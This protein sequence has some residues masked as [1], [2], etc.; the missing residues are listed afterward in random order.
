MPERIQA[1]GLA[2]VAGGALT[3]L[4]QLITAIPVEWGAAG[5]LIAGCG[6]FFWTVA[7]QGIQQLIGIR[8]DLVRHGERL[9]V[10][11]AGQAELR[12]TLRA[13]LRGED[14]PAPE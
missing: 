5:P 8:E 1:L 14:R 12:Q 11:Q 6:W 9:L 2:T 3:I 10:L 13:G 7:N 4:P